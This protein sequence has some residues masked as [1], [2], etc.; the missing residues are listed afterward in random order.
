[1]NIEELATQLLFTTAPILIEQN[2]NKTSAGTCFFYNAQ[3]VSNPNLQVPLLITN[4]HVIKNGKRGIVQMFKIDNNGKPKLND[5]LKIEFDT[6]FLLSAFINEPLDLAAFPIAPLID[7]ASTK[8]SPVF[9]RAIDRHILP[10]SET[11]NG[12][13]AIEEVIFI[14]YPSGIVDSVSGLPIVRKGITATPVWGDFQGEKRY[15]ID[16]G[17]YPG[18]SGSPVFI[19]NQGGYSSGGG[20]VVGT[21]IYFIGVI[22]QTML[23][24]DEDGRAFL[25]LGKVIKINAFETFIAYIQDKI[26]GRA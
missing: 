16:A 23:R 17:V 11:I 8:G 14:G 19:Y 26:V 10:S 1:M 12:L 15:L 18:S 22:S 25:G 6:S 20:F 13:S 5:R 4:Y 2:D 9:F 3:H 7:L 21:R 24:K